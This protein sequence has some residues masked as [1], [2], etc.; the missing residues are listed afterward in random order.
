MVAG[1]QPNYLPHLGFF[2]KM[3]QVDTFVIV[4]NVQ[5][6]K[7][8]PFGWMHRN[9]SIAVLAHAVSMRVRPGPSSRL[10]VWMRVAAFP[11]S[12]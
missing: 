3:A 7:R 10:I 11:I 2:H 9:K 4:D 6:V 8:G 12:P 1:H 5:F